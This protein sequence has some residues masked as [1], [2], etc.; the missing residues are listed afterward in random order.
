MEICKYCKTFFPYYK[1]VFFFHCANYWILTSTMLSFLIS[2]PLSATCWLY[3]L[4]MKTKVAELIILY[5]VFILL[6]LTW[7]LHVM[8]LQ[9][10]YSLKCTVNEM[11]VYIPIVIMTLG[12]LCKR[13]MSIFCISN[14]LSQES[15]YLYFMSRYCG[16]IFNMATQYYPYSWLFMWS[17]W[18]LNFKT[19]FLHVM[20][21]IASSLNK[22]CLVGSTDTDNT[23]Y[24]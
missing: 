10:L 22:L 5:N 18:Q 1:S 12:D 8:F 21:I 16:Y 13:W 17:I 14:C 11:Q 3:V 2:C 19:S 15:N 6:N 4:I 23:K 9:K 7:T 20:H 24:K